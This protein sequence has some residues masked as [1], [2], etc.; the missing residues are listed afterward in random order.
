MPTL[1]STRPRH[2]GRPRTADTPPSDWTHIISPSKFGG[3]GRIDPDAFEIRYHPPKAHGNG[4]GTVEIILGEETAKSIDLR[5][6]AILRINTDLKRG[7]LETAPSGT[8]GAL[9]V[10]GK[11][12]LRIRAPGR[13]FPAQVVEAIDAA[14]I[15]P[16]G[17]TTRLGIDL[18]VKA[19]GRGLEFDLPASRARRSS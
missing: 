10:T 14:T 2:P 13:N 8:V 5:G 4:K 9:R 6:S 19:N 1:T 7:R 18:Q 17:T 12:T 3:R 16:M 15:P 11:R